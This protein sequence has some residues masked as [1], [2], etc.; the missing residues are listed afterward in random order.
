MRCQRI[1]AYW[2]FF[3]EWRLWHAGLRKLDAPAEGKGLRA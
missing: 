3:I 1:I 2:V